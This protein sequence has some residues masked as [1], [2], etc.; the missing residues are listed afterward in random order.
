MAN[1]YRNTIAELIGY[2]NPDQ[3][4]WLERFTVSLGQGKEKTKRQYKRVIVQFL[5]YTNKIEIDFTQCTVIEISGFFDSFGYERLT[6]SSKKAYLSMLS[7]FYRYVICY[8]HC[9]MGDNPAF[10][11]REQERQS[12]KIVDPKRNWFD[13]WQ[14]QKLLNARRGGFREG[15]PAYVVERDIAIMWTLYG[16][17]M[18]REEISNLT[19]NQFNP[20]LHTIN[21]LGKGNNRR[22]VAI[23]PSAQ[24]VLQG[25]INE[26]RDQFNPPNNEQAMFVHRAPSGEVNAMTYSQIGNL[27]NQVIKLSGIFT[28]KDGK[29]IGDTGTHV[30]RRSHATLI[31]KK[32]KDSKLVQAQ[33]GH[34]SPTTT[35]IYTMLTDDDRINAIVDKVNIT[36]DQS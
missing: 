3:L 35:A 28:V 1:P 26:I 30:F 7:S 9:E 22:V 6:A 14:F 13:E 12:L 31:Q 20:K 23:L 8:G 2:L 17:G 4:D 34:S 29:T 25:Y 27:A 19:V 11:Y 10:I 21:V 18:R 32:T 15:E 33:L 36:T 24:E 5:H 16:T